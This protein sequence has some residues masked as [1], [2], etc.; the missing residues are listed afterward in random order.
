MS[1]LIKSSLIAV[2]SLAVFASEASAQY[3]NPT[4]ASQAHVHQPGGLGLDL[5]LRDGGFNP[6]LGAG[7]G[8]VGAGVGTGIGRNGIGL[9]ANTGV[10][11]LG[12]STDGGLSQNG[13]GVRASGGIANTG[14]ALEGGVSGRG[15]GLGASAKV[16]G[17]GGGASLGVGD[18]GPGLGASVAFG[19]LGTLLIGSHRNSYPGA[20]QTAAHMYPNQHASYYTPQHYGNSPYYQTAPVQRPHYTRPVAAP[21]A[22]YQNA[23]PA[24]RQAPYQRQYAAPSCPVNWTC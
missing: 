6:N 10:G 21:R 16:L 14:A 20:E 7:I 13:L 1:Y 18:R 4:P 24:Y 19:P 3:Y 11:P 15:V 2:T 5:G 12:I 9:G 23:Y 22:Y 8:Q 17:F